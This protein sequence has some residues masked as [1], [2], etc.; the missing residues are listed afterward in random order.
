MRKN[1]Q[2]LPPESRPRFAVR[3]CGRDLPLEMQRKL[4]GI[5]AARIGRRKRPQRTE[6]RKRHHHHQGQDSITGKGKGYAASGSEES[7][8]DLPQ[9]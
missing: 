5:I 3:K 9:H 2:V 1:G 8:V 7:Y 6:M 4:A